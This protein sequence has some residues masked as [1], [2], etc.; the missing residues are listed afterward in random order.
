ME[1]ID[2]TLTELKELAKENGIK[3]IFLNIKKMN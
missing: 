2:L 1:Y 3:K